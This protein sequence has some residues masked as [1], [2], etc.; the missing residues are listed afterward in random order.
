[1]FKW[2]LNP[3][4]AILKYFLSPKIA[5]TCNLEADMSR[6]ST[7]V[8]ITE[9][10]YYLNS[11]ALS[12]RTLPAVSGIY[13]II[14]DEITLV[15]SSI[16]RI[17]SRAIRAIESLGFPREAITRLIITH[18]HLDHAGAAG[19]LVQQLPW[20]KVYVQ[21]K[22]ARHL[23]NP[24][25]L[26]QSAADVYGSVEEVFR[27]HGEFVAVPEKNVIPVSNL[28]IPEK[29]GHTLQ[30]F[31][32][33]G[34]APP[35]LCVYD[36]QSKGIFSG[37]AAGHYYP[38]DG[39]VYPA[40]APPSFNLQDS[41]NTLKLMDKLNS[42]YLFF[43]QFGAAKN[44]KKII[45]KAWQQLS[46]FDELIQKMRSEGKSEEEMIQT[47]RESTGLSTDAKRSD[48]RSQNTFLT[49]LW[50]FLRYSQKKNSF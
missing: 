41:F 11:L 16:K 6:N 29:N 45:S 8:Q 10:I 46:Q 5:I 36:D 48:I 34:H 9:N 3:L 31:S 2:I 14:R 39:M 21:E 1:M 44:P 43:S 27:I 38:Y 4:Y 17:A 42:Q 33:P 25:R 18:I 24:D 35:P 47:L 22:G 15:E 28:S 37:E 20:L 23:I 49:T 13:I 32:A 7:L 40:G 12:S 30:L 19:W 50:G 26:I